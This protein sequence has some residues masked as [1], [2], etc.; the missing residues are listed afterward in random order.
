MDKSSSFLIYVFFFEIWLLEIWLIYLNYN[1]CKE[2]LLLNYN[3]NVK[4]KIYVIVRKFFFF[5]KADDILRGK[6]CGIFAKYSS[7]IRFSNRKF[8]IICSANYHF[9]LFLKNILWL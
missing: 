6:V 7:E 1:F 4:V 3:K 8:H 5:L 2:I 9:R